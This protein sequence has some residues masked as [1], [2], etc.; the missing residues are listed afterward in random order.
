MNITDIQ[1]SPLHWVFESCQNLAKEYQIEVSGSELIGLIPKNAMIE[2]GYF[3][4]ATCKDPQEALEIAKS[5]EAEDFDI[6]FDF[7]YSID[8][9]IDC[10][11]E[12]P[13]D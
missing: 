9:D 3:F 11:K 13:N 1:S 8:V 4:N 5:Q 2:A 6:E 12:K 10:I 7:N